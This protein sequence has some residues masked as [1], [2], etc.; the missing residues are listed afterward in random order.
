MS[1]VILP[2]ELHVGLTE[3][4]ADAVLQ[5]DFFIC[6]IM[7]LDFSMFSKYSAY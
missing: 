4:L 1:E 6:S 2:L 3:T 7:L 5:S